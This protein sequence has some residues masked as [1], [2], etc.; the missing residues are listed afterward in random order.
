MGIVRL[1][2]KVEA[3]PEQQ[4]EKSLV[5]RQT[6]LQLFGIIAF[7]LLLPFIACRVLDIHLR[8]AMQPRWLIYLAMITH[9]LFSF[10]VVLLL[11]GISKCRK[12][13][14]KIVITALMIFAMFI[15]LIALYAVFSTDRESE[16][17]VA[18]EFYDH[19]DPNADFTEADPESLA[20]QEVSDALELLDNPHSFLVTAANFIPFN[21]DYFHFYIDSAVVPDGASDAEIERLYAQNRQR[22]SI[23]HRLSRFYDWVFVRIDS[24]NFQS[25][26]DKIKIVLLRD[27]GAIDYK[28]YAQRIDMLDLAYRELDASTDEANGFYQIYE[29]ATEH[30]LKWDLYAAEFITDP[31]I[32][33]TVEGDDQTKDLLLW[34]YTFW[35]RRHNEGTLWNWR[36]ALDQLLEVHPNTHY[37]V[38]ELLN[39]RELMR[40]AEQRAVAFLK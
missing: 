19:D 40:N 31:Y 17:A 22:D 12:M 30:P 33:S 1:T 23:T 34:A 20:F 7:A 32:R 29:Y 18:D 28:Q 10:A 35:G 4:A 13:G 36:Y 2:N 38:Q 25:M 11:R 24:E 3:D 6:K 39:Q 14:W 9:A 15:Y 8:I 26:I 5:E 16:Y 21:P 37:P 27:G